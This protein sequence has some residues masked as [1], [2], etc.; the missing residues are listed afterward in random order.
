MTRTG[1]LTQDQLVGVLLAHL[2]QW[3]HRS[4]HRHK[5]V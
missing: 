1:Q 5:G 3:E 4:K 2:E